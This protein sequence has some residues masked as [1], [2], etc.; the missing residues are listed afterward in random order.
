M[1]ICQRVPVCCVMGSCMQ[2]Y[3]FSA[4]VWICEWVSLSVFVCVCVCLHVGVSLYMCVYIYSVYACICEP[5]CVRVACCIVSIYVCTH[6]VYMHVFMNLCSCLSPLQIL[7]RMWE[8]TFLSTWISTIIELLFSPFCR[9]HDLLSCPRSGSL[10]PG[11][12]GLRFVITERN[13]RSWE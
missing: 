8:L 3:V 10:A 9:P 2:F 11:S 4:F 5:V 13:W 12:K 7:V 6:T 1:C